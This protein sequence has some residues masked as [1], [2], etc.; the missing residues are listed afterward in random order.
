MHYDSTPLVKRYGAWDSSPDH[1]QHRDED[2]DHQHVGGD[3][4]FLAGLRGHH[5]VHAAVPQDTHGGGLGRLTETERSGC[6]G[7]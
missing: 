2:S 6:R 1:G 4:R 5:A 3:L 7:L